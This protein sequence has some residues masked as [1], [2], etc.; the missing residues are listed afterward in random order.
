VVEPAGRVDVEPAVAAL[1]GQ[2]VLAELGEPLGDEQLGVGPQPGEV[3]D[4]R[5]QR[6]GQHRPEAA[7]ER[8]ALRPLVVHGAAVDHEVADRRRPLVRHHQ[9]VAPVEHGRHDPDRRDDARDRHVPVEETELVRPEHLWV[10]LALGP[11]DRQARHRGRALDRHEAIA[12]TVDDEQRRVGQ[13]P[14]Q[15]DRHDRV[16]AAAEGDE[17]PLGRVGLEASF[18]LGCRPGRGRL[19]AFEPGFRVSLHRVGRRAPER[20][21]VDA[22]VGQVEPVAV[23]VLA[24]AVEVEAL[25]ELTLEVVQWRRR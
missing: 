1:E 24:E 12:G 19:C 13:R 4:S 11:H 18:R 14:D 20:R 8:Q 7:L 6:R 23:G 9:G 22:Q 2:V 10:D 3:I 15:L 21:C 17:R 25:Q 16:D 5:A